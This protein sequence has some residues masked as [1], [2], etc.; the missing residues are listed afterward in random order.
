VTVHESPIKAAEYQLVL[1]VPESHKVLAISEAEGYRLPS[2]K[3]PRWTRP[4]EQLQK[5]VKA[6]W[7][8][9]VIVLDFLSSSGSSKVCAV[10]EVLVSDANN[11]LKSTTV[12]QLPSAALEEQ[13]RAQVESMLFGIAGS[14]GPFSRIGWI[15]E[16]IVWVESE[17]GRKLSSRSAIEQFNAGGPFSLVRFHT[18]DDRDY[19]LK[20]TGGPNAH[21]PSI[22]AF[23]AKLCGEYLPEVISSRPAW[24]AWL[25]SG[26]APSMGAMP[27]DPFELFTVLE[28]AVECMAEL[29]MRTQG[30]SLDLLD[31]GAF[32]QGIGVF[33][34]HSAELFD[35]LEE[36]MSLQNSTKVPRLERRRLREIRT[37]FDEVCGRVEDLGIDDTIV[38]GDLNCGNIVKG[39]GH[40]QFIDW[41][42]A[43]LGNP[44]VSLQHLLLL[45]KVDSAEVGAFSNRVLKRR[46]LDVWLK[47]CN[48]DAFRQGFVYMP[49]LAVASTL[50][51][52]GNWLRSSRRNEP[53]LQSYARSLARHMDRATRELESLEILCQ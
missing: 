3:I 18:E 21:E 15:D 49:M 19:W 7:G 44:L 6:A 22:T 25:M 14:S 48:P 16:A 33:Q 35:F 32:D 51:G 23:L 24:N 36:A 10:A 39:I 37:V 42:E 50:Y 31:A 53:R 4:A 5:A 52:R 34:E 46:Y 45:N 13:H 38:H 12:A 30:Q 2:V 17:T 8:V 28:D 27:N 9:H 26:E 41:S 40:C 43:Y 29:Q 47:T 1:V 20:A 11:G